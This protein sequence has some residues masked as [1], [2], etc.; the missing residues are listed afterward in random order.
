MPRG[1]Q[2]TNRQQILPGHSPQSSDEG[3]VL[4]SRWEEPGF[5]SGRVENQSALSAVSESLIEGSLSGEVGQTLT[6]QKVTE[7]HSVVVKRG[8]YE[9]TPAD[10][11]TLEPHMWLNDQVSLHHYKFLMSHRCQRI[12][13]QE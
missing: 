9:L 6:Q 4:D 12:T 5:T 13:V 2:S 3:I 10:L 11:K 7:Q 8:G 1:Q